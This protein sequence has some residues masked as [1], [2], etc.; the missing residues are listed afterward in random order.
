MINKK[1]PP[2]F[3]Y[4]EI[5]QPQRNVAT[6]PTSGDKPPLSHFSFGHLYGLCHSLYNVPHVVPNHSIPTSCPTS[7]W[8]KRRWLAVVMLTC[9]SPGEAENLGRLVWLKR[10]LRVGCQV[11]LSHEKKKLIAF[12]GSSCLVNRDPYT[13]FIIIPIW[14][15]RMSHPL[16]N[17]TNQGFFH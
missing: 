12:H 10:R 9:T 7:P 6:Q 8:R 16:Y 13:W 5:P 17:L 4:W 14:V 3:W 1:C 2:D 15:G 11:Q